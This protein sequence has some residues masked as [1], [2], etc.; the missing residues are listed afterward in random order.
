MTDRADD[1]AD[2]VIDSTHAYRNGREDSQAPDWGASVGTGRQ[3]DMV[4]QRLQLG[5]L[6]A[7]KE[8]DYID[9]ISLSADYLLG[10]NPSGEV[11]V[12]GLGSRPPREPLHTDSLA[13]IKD[14]GMP[15]VPGIPVYG[16]VNGMPGAYWYDPIDA[17]FYPVFDDQPLGLRISD[18]RASVNM[19]EFSVWEMQAP[20]AELFS[21]LLEGD[22]TPPADWLPGGAAH[23]DTLPPFDA[24]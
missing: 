7:Q 17:S 14:K 19:N 15:P 20:M 2:M 9:A 24:E 22:M 3:V 23:R 16:P 12:S 1:M 6:S 18:T 10:C 5:G 4:Y 13:F 8:Q 21:A 11:F